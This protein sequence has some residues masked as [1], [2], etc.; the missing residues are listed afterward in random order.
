MSLEVVILAAGLGKRMNSNIPK[1]LHKVANKYMLFHVIETAEKLNTTKIHLVLGKGIDLV[2]KALLELPESI[3]NKIEVSEQKERLG[4][5]HALMCAMDSINN[6]NDVLVLYG[7]TPLTP[8]EDLDN[9]YNALGYNDYAILTADIPNPFGYGRIIKNADGQAIAI[10]EEK[11][12][13]QEQKK[14][15][16]INTGIVLGKASIFKN[17]LKDI[18]NN[19]AQKEYYLT[20]LLEIL[21]KNNKKAITVRASNF[22]LLAGVNSIYQLHFVERTY[23]RYKAIELL[24]KGL[25]IN[26]INRFDLRGNITF[27]QDCF[28]DNNVIIEGN[29][30]LGNNVQI[31]QGCVIKD[32]EISDNSIISPY[33]I[34]EKSIL[35]IHTTIG[36][37]ARLRPGN[38]LH[39]EVHIG[40]FVEVKNSEIAYGTKAG[41]LSYLGDSTIGRDVNIGAGTITCNYDGANKHRTTIEDDVFIG[42]DTQLV[43]P[44][45]VCKGA[46]VGA[47]ATV[48]KTVHENELFVTRSPSRT[49]AN[50]KR[51]TKKK[52]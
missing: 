27:G 34:M 19:N 5:A 36:P 50:Y 30:V 40:N 10:V 49:I 28:I 4:T 43:A 47:G 52:K 32:C 1:V 42:S 17:Y 15:T 51:P 45:K 9:L 31:G 7:D 24:N 25:H 8:K 13:N 33:T 35:K 11:D 41:H 14:I 29:V 12:A 2:Q 48:T 20:D 22:E 18:N 26:D 38:V 3:Q 16:E 46:T 21:V 39:D 6:D 44:V 23:Q 37:F